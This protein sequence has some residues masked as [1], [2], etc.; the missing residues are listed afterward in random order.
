MSVAQARTA[1]LVAS[2]AKIVD[3]H[4]KLSVEMAVVRWLR[5]ELA[6]DVR[7]WS[8]LADDLGSPSPSGEKDDLSS[9]TLNCG[10]RE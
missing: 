10:F 5:R 4:Q 9:L 8:N 6:T 7:E 1:F 3:Q 2:L